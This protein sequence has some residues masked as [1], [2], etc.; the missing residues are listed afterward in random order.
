MWKDTLMNKFSDTFFERLSRFFYY[1]K[2]KVGNDDHTLSLKT[3][4]PIKNALE[5]SNFKILKEE[6]FK[7]HFFLIA[8][9]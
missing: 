4:N 7:R 9:K 2:N 1:K 6:T 5:R 8:E 3:T